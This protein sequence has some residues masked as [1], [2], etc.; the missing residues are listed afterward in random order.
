MFRES[1]TMDTDCDIPEVIGFYVPKDRNLSQPRSPS[2][3]RELTGD[4]R[5]T[6]EV[7]VR[8]KGVVLTRDPLYLFF[9]IEEL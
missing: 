4:E 1:F 8:P 2:L 6:T 5:D 7:R 9:R 3:L